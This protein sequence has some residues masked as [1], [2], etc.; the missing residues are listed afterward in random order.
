MVMF[1]IIKAAPLLILHGSISTR[2]TLI[3]RVV[4][5]N[6]MDVLCLISHIQQVDPNGTSE[7]SP[8]RVLIDCGAT[9]SV[10]FHTFA[11]M[12]QPHPTPLGYDLEFSMPRRERCYVDRVY[13]GCPVMVED[14]VMPANLISLDIVDFDVILGTDWLHCNRAKIDYYGKTVTFHRPGLPKVTFVGEPS[15]VRH[16]ISAMKTKRLL[17]KGCQGY[18]AHVELNDNGPNSVED[19]CVVRYFPDVFPDDL[20]GLPLDRD[21]EFAIDLLPGTDPIS[22]T[23]YRMAPA[24]LKELKVQLQELVDKLKIKREDVPKTA[25]RTRYAQGI[26]VNSQKVATVEDWEQPRTV[27]EQLKYYLTH[28]LVLA[29]SDDSGNF[30]VYS[31][32]SLNG[33]G[34][35][36]MQHGRV[37]VYALRQ[38]EPHKKNYPTHDLELV[39][40]I[41]ALK[42][43]RHYLYGGKCKIFTDH[44][45]LQYLFTQRD[46]NLRQQRWIELLSDYDCTIKYHHGRE[47]AVAN[48]L[49]RK[50]PARL[51]AIYD[52]HMIDEETH[53]IIQARNRGKKKDFRIR[54]TDGMLKQENIMY[55]P[56]N[57]E[58]KKEILDEAHISAYAM[59]PGGETYPEDERSQGQLGGYDPSTYQ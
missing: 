35:V 31:D 27:T 6:I 47:N 1:I 53:E 2:R 17:S 32:A 23:S 24:E 37:I 5:L 34:C 18:L 57:A 11:L 50:T 8:S 36:L 41:F 10:V 19:V 56:N 49:S 16:V 59:H 7:D 15:G 38:L 48:A 20:P 42:I 52:C 3:I 46:L 9:H 40:I 55:V 44:K 45:S 43:W 21:V 26:R 30:E 33:L 14:V 13:L 51:N 22:L 58:L 29:L 4:T 12:T 39:A 25:F 54:Q 28:A